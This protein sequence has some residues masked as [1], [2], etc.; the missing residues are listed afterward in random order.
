C[1]IHALPVDAAGNPARWTKVLDLGPQSWLCGTV[2]VV[3]KNRVVRSA[4][5][6]D[7][8]FVMGKREPMHASSVSALAGLAWRSARSIK[9]V[10]DLAGCEIRGRKAEK[11]IIVSVDAGPVAVHDVGSIPVEKRADLPD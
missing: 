9:A 4:G 6:P 10:K 5:E 3:N 1:W 11:T 2:H 8:G 7:G